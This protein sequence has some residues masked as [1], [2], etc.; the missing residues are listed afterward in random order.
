M[1]ERAKGS[2][3]EVK[4][5]MVKKQVQQVKIVIKGKGVKMGR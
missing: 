4:R 3:G 1:R 5:S 2:V